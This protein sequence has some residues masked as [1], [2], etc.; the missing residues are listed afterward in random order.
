MQGINGR[1]PAPDDS[2]EVRGWLLVL[3][4]VLL[5]WQP[6]NFAVSASQALLALPIRGLPVALVLTVR[7][8]VTAFGAAAALA[9]LRRRQAAVRMTILALAATAALDVFVE[10]TPYFPTN[11]VPGDAP[12]YAAGSIVFYSAWVVY[13]ARS[14]RVK[15]TL[16]S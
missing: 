6:V 1:M 5:V 11:R 10:A 2:E 15:R 16:I 4:L 13:L 14:A 9:I 7:L 8:L 3:C 12:L